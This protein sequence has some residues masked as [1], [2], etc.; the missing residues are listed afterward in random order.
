MISNNN[1]KSFFCDTV[2]PIYDSALLGCCL[3]PSLQDT[4]NG[5]A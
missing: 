4:L 1:D 3:V 2:L 5:V